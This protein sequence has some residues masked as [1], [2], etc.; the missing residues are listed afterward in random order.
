[1]VR[2]R[3]TWIGPRTAG[4]WRENAGR[5]WMDDVDEES[6]MVL[7]ESA[8]RNG[9]YEGFCPLVVSNH[10]RPITDVR[11]ANPRLRLREW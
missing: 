9:T 3:R 10:A 1:M 2:G 7:E 5:C 4:G 11:E 8:G 6:L